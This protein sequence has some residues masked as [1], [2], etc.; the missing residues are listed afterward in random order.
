MFMLCGSTSEIPY[1]IPHENCCEH[2]DYVKNSY[3]GKYWKR[4]HE[5]SYVTTN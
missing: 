4:L 2:S 3:V 5:G 1:L